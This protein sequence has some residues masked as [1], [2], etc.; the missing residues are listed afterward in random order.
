M[1]EDIWQQ[2]LLKLVLHDRRNLR[3]S[4]WTPLLGAMENVG[5]NL[6][7]FLRGERWQVSRMVGFIASSLGLA[8]MIVECVAFES[9]IGCLET[10]Y[11]S[12]DAIVSHK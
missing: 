2:E 4:Q 1:L 11:P 5:D 10:V 7:N 8:P 12:H 9:N 3:E 6:V